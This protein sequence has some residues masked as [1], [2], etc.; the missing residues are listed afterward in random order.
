MQLTTSYQ[1]LD[2]S[3][4]G[5]SGG[6]LYIRYY[7]R[8]TKQDITN[9][10][11][12]VEYQARTYYQNSTYIY[13]AGG[14][15]RIDGSAAP[16]KTVD[17]TRITQGETTWVTTG[18]W[19]YHSDDGSGRA[20]GEAHIEFPNFGWYKSA[21]LTADLP[22][23]A[24]KALIT[25]TSN[26]N[27]ESNPTIGY[28]NIAGSAVTSL[29]CCISYDSN[30]DFEYRKVPLD[31]TSY[32]YV[33]SEVQREKL[34]KDLTTSNSRTVYMYLKTV[35]GGTTLYDKKSVVFSLVNASPTIS[36][37]VEDA[38]QTTIALTG[39][40]TK[41][42]N[43]YS[44]AKY[45]IQYSLK[46]HATK[47]ELRLRNGSNVT[48]TATGTIKPQSGVFQ[49]EI[50]DSRGNSSEVQKTLSFI[51]YSN[52]SA[53]AKVE[54]I[55][56]DGNLT[57]IISGKFWNG[58]FGA[59]K[60]EIVVKYKISANSNV[61]P[62]NYEVWKVATATISGDSFK[63]QV[64]VTGLDYRTPYVLEFQAFDKLSTSNIPTQK[65]ACT[66]IFD[67][68]ENDFN[69]NVRAHAT[70]GMTIDKGLT[71]TG[72][73]SV[74]NIESVLGMTQYGD[75]KKQDFGILT[76]RIRNAT[77]EIVESVDT[78]NLF[79][80]KFSSRLMI[81]AVRV[82]CQTSMTN[83]GNLSEG[84]VDLSGLSFIKGFK[85]AK[86][87]FVFVS[88]NSSAGIWLESVTDINTVNYGKYYFARN[89]SAVGYNVKFNGIFL[90]IGRW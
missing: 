64:N 4:V 70:S 40:K 79:A 63:A 39:D 3:Y 19:I 48:Y 15:V 41:L 1:K 22:K 18:A 14:Q 69:F 10:R 47:K 12:Y 11:T 44:D 27:D 20:W 5:S 23:I 51:Q 72:M 71:L 46:K 43:K 6:D 55:T 80:I 62:A 56:P 78:G 36:L 57:F 33:L 89:Q 34:R 38:N 53:T 32:T 74:E 42:I 25:S 60:N 84:F 8:Y 24:R 21:Y 68:G 90:F 13:D 26:F 76:E 82:N 86:P 2:E 67:W 61:Q 52:V 87:P 88:N 45:N 77:R 30:I 31:K 7:A 58:H 28:K 59:V 85:F 81:Y 66:P 75:V 17:A 29:E 65:I 37:T 50:I 35:I 9:N 73:E 54:K 16:R 83:W 49:A